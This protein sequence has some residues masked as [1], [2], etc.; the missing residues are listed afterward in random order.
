MPV[1]KLVI[2]AED[3]V[4][5]CAYMRRE[6]NKKG[7]NFTEHITSSLQTCYGFYP[8]RP[9]WVYTFDVLGTDVFIEVNVTDNKKFILC[10]LKHNIR[11]KH[12]SNIHEQ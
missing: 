1:D 11:T 3:Y 10:I 7:I 8:A 9:G 4:K 6:L 12:F 5:L 2:Y